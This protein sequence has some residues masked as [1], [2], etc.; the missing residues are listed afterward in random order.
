MPH[1]APVTGYDFHELR[2]Q[3]ASDTARIFYIAM[4]GRR[5]VLLHAFTK[6]TQKAPRSELETA[7]K[8]LANL[9]GGR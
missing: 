6:K 3:F 1:A 4:T 8:R 2:I 5:L 7:Q 9:R